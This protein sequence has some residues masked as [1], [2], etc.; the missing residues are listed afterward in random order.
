MLKRTFNKTGWE[1]GVVG[2]GTWG[3]GGQWGRVEANEAVAAVEAAIDE[4]SNFIDTADVYGDPP[5]ESERLLARVIATRRDRLIVASKVGNFARR[6]GH[7]LSFSHW[8]HVTLCCDASL[9]RLKTDYIDLYFCHLPHCTEPDVLLEGFD[10]LVRAG[11]IRAFGISTDRLDVAEA[12]H[13]DPR[14]AAVQLEYS[15]L[16]RDAETDLLPYCEARQTS[17][18]IRGPLAKGVAT[19]KFN[20]QS[21]FAD[22]IR[23]GWNHGEGRAEFARRLDVVQRLRERLP[24]GVDLGQIAI[25]FA[26]AHPAVTVV[27][28]GAK[29]ATQARKNALAGAQPLDESL[30]RIVRSSS[31]EYSR[32]ATE[33]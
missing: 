1:V 21:V 33:S 10:R 22:E 29:N 6:Q 11:K 31:A 9:G 28:P 18:I 8:L 13:R 32:P 14:C 3:I 30:L 25:Q 19:G 27:I 4:G 15:Y 23:K 7:G 12:F 24:P 16:R 2:I 17:A 5:G 26:L 20:D